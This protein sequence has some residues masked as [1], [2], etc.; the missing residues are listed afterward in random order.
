[1]TVERAT[2]WVLWAFIIVFFL[3]AVLSMWNDSP[4]FD[5]M[6]NPSVGYAE[7]FVRDLSLYHDHPP[8]S[9]V[10]TAL[11]LLAFKPAIPFDHDSWQK[12]AQGMKD[13]YDFAHEFFYVANQNAHTMLLW[14]RLPIVLLSLLLGLLVFKWAQLLFGNRAGLFALL[15]YSFEPNIIAHSRLATNDLIVTLFIFATIFQF[16][17]YTQSPSSKSLVLT[18]ITLGLALISKFSAVM[19]FPMLFILAFVAQKGEFSN[20][21]ANDPIMPFKK[22][23]VIIERIPLALKAVALISAVAI[24]VVLL[25]Y[26]TQWQLY[27]KGFYDTVAHYEGGHDAFLMGKHSTDGWWGYFPIAFLLKT[28]IPFLIFIL[29]SVLFLSFKKEKGEYFL[30]IPVGIIGASAL[31]SH[32]NIGIRHIL[33]IYPFLIVL[34]S[35]ITMIKFSKPRFFGSCFAGLGLWYVFSSV[36][37]FPSYLAYF[38]E[39]VGPGRGYQY[40]V[41]SNSDWGQ[42]LKRLKVFMDQKG[43]KKL[44]LSYFGTADPCFYGIKPIYLP[45]SRPPCSQEPDGGRPDF[46]AI[47][48][49]NLQSV[50]LPDKKSF[51]WLKAYEPIGRIGYSIFVYNIQGDESAHNNLGILYLNYGMVKEAVKEFHLVVDLS[52]KEAVAYANLGFAYSRLSFFDRA[53]AA[54]REALKLDSDNSVAKAGLKGIERLKKKKHQRL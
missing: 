1:M 19:L 54:Y 49:T 53:E 6:V 31:L 28:P 13:R 44:Y 2:P 27:I 20:E 38:N 26:G 43:I 16:W 11:P 36:S 37:I 15:L 33:P 5:E 23:K 8:L 35:S 17:R 9:R 14:S 45:S 32:I 4:T 41:D 24:G 52:P 51:D 10:F 39:F 18:G 29:I 48:T 46:I 47:S 40:L 30:L 50:Y 42:D 12:R 22:Y 7:L 21:N 3:Q 34:A 25:F